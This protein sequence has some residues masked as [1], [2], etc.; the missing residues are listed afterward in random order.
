M[1]AALGRILIQRGEY[2]EAAELLGPFE[3][4]FVAAGLAAR[5]GLQ[6]G[7]EPDLS[8]AFSALD[9][10]DL[11]GA[12]D[13]LQ[14]ALA[15]ASDPDTRDRLRRVMVAIFTELGPGDPLAREHRR[16]LSAALN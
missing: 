8:D 7:G 14:N 5:A 12:L 2:D 6:A 9:A 4:D 13:R 16:R 3:S 1:A 10:G 15:E 11:P